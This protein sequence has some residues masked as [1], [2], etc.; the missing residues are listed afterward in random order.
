MCGATTLTT[1][2]TDKVVVRYTWRRN[3]AVAAGWV[4]TKYETL[5]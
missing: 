1:I 3:T 5:P 4:M 2:S